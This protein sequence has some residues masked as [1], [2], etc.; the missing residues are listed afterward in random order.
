MCTTSFSHQHY[1][2]IYIPRQLAAVELSAQV[3]TD[4]VEFWTENET[5]AG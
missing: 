2:M 5:Q 4:A 3:E 1:L